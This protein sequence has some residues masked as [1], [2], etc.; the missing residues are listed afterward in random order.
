MNERTVFAQ[1]ALVQSKAVQTSSPS[2]SSIHPIVQCD[3][4]K[5]GCR[6]KS[7]CQPNEWE[8]SSRKSG[9][10]SE[11][12]GMFVSRLEPKYRRAPLKYPSLH[13]E[14][15]GCGKDSRGELVDVSN[16]AEIEVS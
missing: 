12:A 2:A 7:H 8:D 13:R 11:L 3:R 9:L 5:I 10:G 4:V 15:A 14:R 6:E 1:Q 16:I